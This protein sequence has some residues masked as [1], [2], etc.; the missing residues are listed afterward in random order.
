M[1][2]C[3]IRRLAMLTHVLMEWLNSDDENSALLLSSKSLFFGGAIVSMI[4]IC[5]CVDVWMC[6]GVVWVWMDGYVVRCEVS[7]VASYMSNVSVQLVMSGRE[8]VFVMMMMMTMTMMLQEVGYEEWRDGKEV[9]VSAVNGEKEK[10]KE[11]KKKKKSHFV[12]NV[13]AVSISSF[14]LSSF[15]KSR[16][17]EMDKLDK[18]MR[19]ARMH[20]SFFLVSLSP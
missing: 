17:S 12:P 3:L 10:G 11:E 18:W 15:R 6:G 20:L 9:C 7:R 14:L 1:S 4:C 19:C 2:T 8:G 16:E 13:L 5:V